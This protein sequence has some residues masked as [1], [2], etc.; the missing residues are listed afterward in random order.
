ARHRFEGVEILGEALPPPA[1]ALGERGAGDVLDALHQADEPV[2]AIGTRRGEANPAVAHHDR[3][4]AMPRRRR[5]IRIPRRLAVVVR[6]DVDPAGRDDQPARVD[7]A[8]ALAGDVPGGGDAI[9]VDR[10]VAGA[11]RRAR[12]V[13]DGAPAQDEIVHAKGLPGW[14]APCPT[15]AQRQ[16]CSR[17]VVGAPWPTHWSTGPAGASRG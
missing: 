14:K 1:D 11:R 9:A 6:V 8:T 16:R 17:G 12:A 7:L 3:G 13:D 15:E 2:V 5:Q 4:D 10:D